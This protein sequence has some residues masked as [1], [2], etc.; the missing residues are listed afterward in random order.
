MQQLNNFKSI[1]MLVA[2]IQS[3]MPS[4]N[5][6]NK[7]NDEDDKDGEDDDEEV[8]VNVNVNFYSALTFKHL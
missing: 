4:T 3:Y 6:I 5:N 1:E 7:N 8:N 2:L